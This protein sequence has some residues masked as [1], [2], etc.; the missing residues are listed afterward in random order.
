M[1][2]V[3]N[4]SG[5]FVT[6]PTVLYRSETRKPHSS[7]SLVAPIFFPHS[8]PFQRLFARHGADNLK[9]GQLCQPMQFSMSWLALTGQR[10]K[11]ER[12]YS[13]RCCHHPR[14]TP[15]LFHR[16]SSAPADGKPLQ[17]HYY[18]TGIVTGAKKEDLFKRKLDLKMKREY[19]PGWN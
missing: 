10:E 5:Y 6:V 4:S 16:R 18:A 15:R 11:P 3:S 17:F 2:A 1:N 7:L 12:H 13:W 19:G 9:A 14:T 8:L